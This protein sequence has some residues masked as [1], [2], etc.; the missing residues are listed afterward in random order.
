MKTKSDVKSQKALKRTVV[1]TMAFCLQVKA[2]LE[3]VFYP[4]VLGVVFRL[5]G[6]G[7]DWIPLEAETFDLMYLALALL[8]FPLFFLFPLT[9]VFCLMSLSYSQT[10]KIS[11]L[12]IILN[13][14][15]AIPALFLGL[16]ST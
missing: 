11:S 5:F 3:I 9:L 14:L 16:T 12:C 4:L 10:K 7:T 2:G 6:V 13:I 15:F 8:V 1:T